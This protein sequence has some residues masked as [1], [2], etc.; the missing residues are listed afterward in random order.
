MARPSEKLSG[1]PA[2]RVDRRH[3]PCGFDDGV[4]WRTR[5]GL[6]VLAS[7]QTLE[8]EFRLVLRDLPGVALYESRIYNANEITP[9]TLRAMEAGLTGATDL[10]VPGVD[11]STVAYACTSGSMVIGD[12]VVRERIHAAR[13]GVAT[14]TPMQATFA[15]FRALGARRVA[16]IAPYQD[17]ICQAMR[18]YILDNGFEVPVMGSWNQSDDVKVARISPASIRDAVLELGAEPDVDAAFVACTSLRMVEQVEALE[19]ALGKPVTSSN[20]ALIWHCLRLAG[21]A[22]AIDGYASLYHCTTA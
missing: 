20:H 5:I 17:D 21:V 8:Y 7:D 19:Q 6:I 11:L 10:L 1:H 3:M 18:G 22:D 2:P 13:P 14:T 15:A 12:D 4:G 16:F 9:E